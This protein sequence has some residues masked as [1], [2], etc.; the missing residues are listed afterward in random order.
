MI[1]LALVWVLIFFFKVN[2]T[3]AGGWQTEK[4]GKYHPGSEAYKALNFPFGSVVINYN[5]III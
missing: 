1:R 3:L 5:K 2:L 4:P